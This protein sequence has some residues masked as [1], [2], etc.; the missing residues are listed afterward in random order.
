MSS[1]TSPSEPDPPRGERAGV[2]LNASASGNARLNQAGRDQHFHITVPLLGAAVILAV[3]VAAFWSPL[4]QLTADSS[5]ASSSPSGSASR[6]EIPVNRSPRVTEAAPP[7][8][9][10]VATTARATV[11]VVTPTASAKPTTATPSPLPDPQDVA[12]A[13]VRVGDCLD[14][15]DTGLGQWSRTAPVVVDCRGASALTRVSWITT[16]PSA[17]PSGAGR[18]SATHRAGDGRT[19]VLCLDRQFRVGQC[20]PAVVNGQSVTSG[21]LTVPWD[22]FAS[23]VPSGAN[24]IMNITAVTTPSTSCPA[25]NG[26]ISASWPVLDGQ[27]KVCAVLYH[28]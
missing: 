10:P 9:D 21:N 13:A 16:A 17:C 27:T 4:Q 24:S 7:V 3:L 6:I 12:F 11:P 22:C 19:T 28:P 15:Y 18:T 23:Q 8:A 25:A 2:H 5:Q 20:F 14:L 26:R 1:G